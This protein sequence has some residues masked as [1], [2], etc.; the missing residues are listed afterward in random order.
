LEAFE[1]IYVDGVFVIAVNL[2]RAVLNEAIAFR[3]ILE[4]EINSGHTKLVIDLS[5]CDYIDSTFFGAIIVFSRMLI[6]MGFK[7]KVV[8]P[9]I[10]G[11]FLFSNPN[12]DKLFDKYI[13]REEAILSFEED[14]QP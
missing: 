5:K 6:D 9:S 8:K 12:T 2:S 13:T 1:K 11:E 7:L 4:E 10:A 14:I 3:K